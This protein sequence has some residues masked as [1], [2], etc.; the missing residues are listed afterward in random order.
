M[1]GSYDI[2][3][4]FDTSNQV[5]SNDFQRM[6][7]ITTSLLDGY[8]LQPT[9]TRLALVVFGDEIEQD[10]TF[11]D[12]A[13]LDY[14]KQRLNDLAR[15]KGNP[16]IDKLLKFADTKLFTPS[17][18]S[19][20][21]VGRVLVL[22]TKKA[23][24]NGVNGLS[25]LSKTLQRKGVNVVVVSIDHDPTNDGFKVVTGNPDDV[26]PVTDIKILKEVFGIVEKKIADAV[27]E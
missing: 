13:S 20:S 3:F 16:R 21:N 7:L 26:V 6:K 1:V 25:T 11:A 9:K 10:L 8:Q 5:T 14:T 17:S 18:G 24:Q 27:G 19:R 22:F 15:I 4:A 12:S 2:A 23:S